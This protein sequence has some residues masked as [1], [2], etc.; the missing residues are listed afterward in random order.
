MVAV[1][2]RVGKCWMCQ[3]HPNDTIHIVNLTSH[4]NHSQYR[5]TVAVAIT[6]VNGEIINDNIKYY[7]AS[8]CQPAMCQSAV[9]TRW[10]AVPCPLSTA[11]D[12][13]DQIGH[14]NTHTDAHTV[15]AL[16]LNASEDIG[17]TQ[18][19]CIV[20]ILRKNYYAF[21][22]CFV[23]GF[24]FISTC[25][26]S[27][28]D[29]LQV[30]AWIGAPYLAVSLSSHWRADDISGLLSPAVS[31]SRGQKTALGTRNFAVAGAKIWNNLPA[32]LRL[33]SQS[34]QTFAKFCI[35]LPTNNQPSLWSEH[36]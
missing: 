16:H 9:S 36:M 11:D 7:G 15:P 14:C 13:T 17:A 12:W 5:I 4:G 34:L 19:K 32:D 22:S 25:L 35:H 27:G 3:C 20:N 6:S 31:L 8:C 23:A 29:G 1:P 10:P 2:Q 30:S 26:Q 21:G 24:R 28:S 33:H 18:V